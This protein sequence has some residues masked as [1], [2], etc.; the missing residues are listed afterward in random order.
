MEASIPTHFVPGSP[1][2]VNL[3]DVMY[4]NPSSFHLIFGAH[5]VGKSVA[6]ELAAAEASKTRVVKYL[7]APPTDMDLFKLF[8]EPPLWLQ[9]FG[10]LRSCVCVIIIFALCTIALIAD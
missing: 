8:Y 6:V 10:Q 5:G 1:D 2:V 7:D 4:S 9:C 3:T